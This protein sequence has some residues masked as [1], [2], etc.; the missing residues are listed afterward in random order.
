M[1]FMLYFM[2]YP[3]RWLISN[4]DCSSWGMLIYYVKESIFPHCPKIVRV[5]CCC[6][7]RPVCITH[8]HTYKYTY[9]HTYILTYILTCI[10]TYIHTYIH[11]CIHTYIHT[12]IHTC[13]HTYIR[14]YVRT[15]IHTYIQMDICL[16]YH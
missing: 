13:I 11:T 6:H 1:H 2:G 14:T 16:V 5:G 8:I 9:I 12:Y 3:R 4:F 10:R 15:Y 7:S